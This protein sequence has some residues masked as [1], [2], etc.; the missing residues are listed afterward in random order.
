MYRHVL[1]WVFHECYHFAVL[2]MVPTACAP[3]MPFLP[4]FLLPQTMEAADLGHIHAVVQS[5]CP[6]VHGSEACLDRLCRQLVS[7]VVSSTEAQY[8]CLRRAQDVELSVSCSDLQRAL[9]GV[10]KE[11]QRCL[12]TWPAVAR[13]DMDAAA[14]EVWRWDRTPVLLETRKEGTASQRRIPAIQSQAAFVHVLRA[15][16]WVPLTRPA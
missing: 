13:Y 6:A 3:S 14:R 1:L 8:D 10:L 4:P 15:E 7:T 12:A 5:T 16:V 11:R 9:V 2:F